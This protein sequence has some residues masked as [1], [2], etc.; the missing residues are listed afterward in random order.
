MFCPENRCTFSLQ[1]VP[2]RGLYIL[3][4]HG[5]PASLQNIPLTNTKEGNGFA[6]KKSNTASTG[7]CLRDSFKS[8]WATTEVV[9]RCFLKTYSNEE[10][11]LPDDQAWELGICQASSD[12]PLFVGRGG[13]RR[14]GK[15]ET[16][17]VPLFCRCLKPRGRSW[18]R[19]SFSTLHS[20]SLAGS[21]A[22]GRK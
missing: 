11:L 17:Q 19:R 13:V 22:P 14:V 10:I 20:S 3:L 16:F 15:K 21:D 6:T 12:K 9:L 4:N 5:R 7:D 18:F 1:W 8:A 2:S